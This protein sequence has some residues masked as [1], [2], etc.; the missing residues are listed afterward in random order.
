MFGSIGTE[1]VIRVAYDLIMK[2]TVLSYPFILGFLLLLLQG[3][4]ETFVASL[5]RSGSYNSQ[6]VETVSFM[7]I[8]F[9][10]SQFD[11]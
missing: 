5:L 11:L 1:S 6:F 3:H 7:Y 2:L 4:Y 10:C 9:H 8:Y